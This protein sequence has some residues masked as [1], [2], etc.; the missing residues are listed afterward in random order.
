MLRI[1][2]LLL[3]LTENG[4]T[5]HCWQ[6]NSEIDVTCRDYFNITRIEENRRHFENFNYQN[7]RPIHDLPRNDPHLQHCDD[8][9]SHQYN[10]KSVCL[11]RV[12]RVTGS[13]SDLPNVQRDC[14]IVPKDFVVGTCP[15]ELKSFGNKIVDY[16]S[17]CN[18]DGC[19]KAEGIK[20]NILNSI[21]LL[22][23]FFMVK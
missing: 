15:E 22:I 11:K 9:F 20:F 10:Q 2:L 17:T 12:Y 19:N 1:F 14:R 13:H 8:S 21:L 6:C 4:F 3:A 23:I 16:C 7:N 18:I 5:L